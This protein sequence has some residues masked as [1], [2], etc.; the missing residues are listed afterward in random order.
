MM[1]VSKMRRRH[2]KAL[3][4]VTEIDSSYT[5]LPSLANT[6]TIGYNFCHKGLSLEPFRLH[7]GFPKAGAGVYSELASA[8]DESSVEIFS[9]FALIG[10][11]KTPERMTKMTRNGTQAIFVPETRFLI[12]LN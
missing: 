8:R 2:K 6:T 3:L 5:F 4:G 9:F 1:T 7:S 10:M 11:A 12:L